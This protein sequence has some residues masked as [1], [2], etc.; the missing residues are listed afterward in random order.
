[1][2]KKENEQVLSTIKLPNLTLKKSLENA[3]SHKKSIKKKFHVPEN[4]LPP[5]PPPRQKKG[6]SLIMLVKCTLCR[7]ILFLIKKLEDGK[8]IVQER[9]E[10]V[11]K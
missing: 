7:P 4:C 11:E 3:I 6:L 5:P 9:K 2:E 1:M 10:Y 8:K